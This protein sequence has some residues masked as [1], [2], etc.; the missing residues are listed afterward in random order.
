MQRVFEI[1]PIG[2]IR[3][4]PEHTE[5]EVFPAYRDALLGLEGFS[6]INV[7]Y[8]FHENDTAEKRRILRVHP[9][10]N[11]SNPLTGVFATHAPV[12]PNLIAFSLCRIIAIDGCRIRIADIDALD[13]TPLID[14]KCYIPPRVDP[15]EVR[16]P[17]WAGNQ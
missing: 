12:R 17:D 8:W 13:G 14:I 5:L 10:R 9:R 7:F 11:R 6:H 4:T 15:E 16:L 3:K 1:F 2:V